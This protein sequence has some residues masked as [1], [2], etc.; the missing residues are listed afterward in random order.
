MTKV[1]SKVIQIGKISVGNRLPFTTIIGPC[2]IESREFAISM[3]EELTELIRDNLAMPFIFKASFDKANRTSIHGKRGVGLDEAMDIFYE[4]KEKF[5]IPILTDAHKEEQCEILAKV[6]DVIQIPAFLCRQT[7]LLVAAGETDKIV[8]VKKG[9]FMAPWDMKHVVEK[10]ASTGNDNIMLTERGTCFGYN[11][12]VNDMRSLPIMANET[13]CPI[14]FDATHSVQMPGGRGQE[15]GGQ[16][17][18]VEPLARAAI[19]IGVAAVFIEAHPNPEKAPSDGPC[20]L[21]M[22]QIERCLKEWKKLDCLVKIP[23]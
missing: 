11:T 3:A 8:N 6:V 19:S 7:D 18:F 23:E 13:G 16:R 21:Y 9:Q 20:M 14:V 2:Q 22:H 4:I 15:S 17:D 5:N 1:K 12:L 10:I